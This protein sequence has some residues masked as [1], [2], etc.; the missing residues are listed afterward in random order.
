V[1]NRWTEQGTET[2][3]GT[4][5]GQR[6]PGNVAE[7]Q[8][9]GSSG[10]GSRPAPQTGSGPSSRTGPGQNEL[11]WENRLQQMQ[12]D[13][14]QNLADG[15]VTAGYK[16]DLHEIIAL[17][18]RAQASEWASF[19]QYWHHYFMASDIH[20]KE[21]QDVFKDHAKDEFEHARMFGDRI[22]QLGGVPC[23][24]PEEIQRLTPTP[25]EYDHDLRSM[26]EADLIGERQAIDFYDEIIRTCGFDDNV[27]RRTFEHVLAEEAEHANDWATLMFAYDGT[28]GRQIESLSDELKQLAK[29]QG[30]ERGQVRRTA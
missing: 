3:E 14:E 5:R 28:T 1:S 12:H 9:S 16:A 4:T 25:V 10:K 8:R 21:V 6:R 11:V 27:T 17:L 18:K 13:A 29:S 2:E 26:M 7:E 24:S 15:A 20:S 23:D 22:Q 19:L 30:P